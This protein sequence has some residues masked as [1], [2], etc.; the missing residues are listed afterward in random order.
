MLNLFRKHATSWLIKV[1]LFLIVIVFIF[2]GGYSYTSKDATRMARVNDQYITVSEYERSYNQLLDMYRR[3]FGPAF[4]EDMI[5]QLNLRQHALNM[6]IDRYVVTEAANNLGLTASAQEVQQQ[7]LRFPAFQKDGMFDKEQYVLLLRQNRLSPDLFEQQLRE[8]LS[9]QNVEKFIKRQAAVTEKEILIEFEFN[10]SPIQISYLEIDPKAY[11]ERVAAGETEI[12]N[13]YEAHKEAYREPEKRKFS[14]VS[15]DTDSLLK[16]VQVSED[17]VKE[18][19]S[20]NQAAYH[21]QAEVRARHILFLINEG[22]G[23]EEVAKTEAE[24]QKVLQEARKKEADFPELAKKHSQCPSA[25]QGGDLGYFT[26]DQMVPSF[27]EAAFAL[28]P[29][30]VSGIVKTQ[31]GL[32]IIKVEDVRPERT[33]ALEE[34]KDEIELL[35]KREKARDIAYNKARDFS[36]LAYAGNDLKK[37][38]QTNNLAVTETKEWLTQTSPPQEIKVSAEAMSTLFNIPEG[39]ISDVVETSDGYLIAQVNAIKAPEVPPYEQVKSQVEQDYKA[40]EAKKMAQQ[41]AAELLADARKMNSLEQVAK[42]RNIEVK[43]SDWFTRTEPDKSLRLRGDALSAMFQLDETK[44]FPEAPIDVNG[45]F[46]T[47]YQL[48]GKKSPAKENLEKERAGILQKLQTQKENQLWQA[49]IEEQRGRS[50]IEIIQQ[51]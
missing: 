16:D 30:E 11:I 20:E 22:A 35:L 3:Q 45:Q 21:K 33:V 7:I 13:Y 27:S 17:E 47:V 46:Y 31:F 50:K 42:N 37:A 40:E 36:D 34:A 9:V 10:Q 8:D 44:P 43:K 23:D 12:K 6:L 19:Y 26:R 25:P 14:M 49:W 1:A 28:Q 18:Y 39:G 38:A 29:G 2:W 5:R 24:A 41:A 51:L 32:H 15:F 48:V 4:S